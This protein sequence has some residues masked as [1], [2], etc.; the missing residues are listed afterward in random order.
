MAE[1]IEVV[2][3]AVLFPRQSQERWNR[4]GPGEARLG[5]LRKR[6]VELGVRVR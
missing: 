1:L 4:R 5:K 6:A 2:A 3:L